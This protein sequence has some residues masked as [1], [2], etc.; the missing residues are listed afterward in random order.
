MPEKRSH[1]SHWMLSD[2]DD[3]GDLLSHLNDY[4][5]LEQLKRRKY[6]SG[7]MKERA[8]GNNTLDGGT[9]P[10]KAVTTRSCA[11]ESR[12]A[13]EGPIQRLMSDGS[14]SD[15]DLLTVL[16]MA[17]QKELY[18]QQQQLQGSQGQH[19]GCNGTFTKTDM[20]MRMPEPPEYSP[21][22]PNSGGAAHC[23]MEQKDVDIAS[24]PQTRLERS[25]EINRLR[26]RRFRARQREKKLREQR[27]KSG[28]PHNGMTVEDKP[29]T[30]ERGL[31]YCRD[32][33][34]TGSSRIKSQHELSQLTATSNDN[35]IFDHELTSE[36][37]AECLSRLQSA[38]GADNLDE[39]ACTVCNRLV[40]RHETCRM[41]DTDNIVLR[42]T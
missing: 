3:P 36:E 35:T 41:D 18:Q 12:L 24:V 37:R 10:I 13:V 7:E 39:C 26:Q 4:Y 28:V 1:P 8:C 19:E 42:P 15:T 6:D 14:D 25:R 34:V 9:C 23:K 11:S 31:S 29:D 33:F 5:L 32:G 40:L 27:V 22:E 17:R 30:E 21:T 2:E 20:P 38:L 16:T